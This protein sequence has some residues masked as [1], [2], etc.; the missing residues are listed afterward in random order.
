[1]GETFTPPVVLR[2]NLPGGYFYSISYP[3][4]SCFVDGQGNAFAAWRE[5]RQYPYSKLFFLTY[6]GST[7]KTD[8]SDAYKTFHH[9][10][11]VASNGTAHAIWSV[12]QGG[13]TNDLYFSTTRG[14]PLFTSHRVFRSMNSAYRLNLFVNSRKMAN[15]VFSDGADLKLLRNLEY[16]TDTVTTLVAGGYPYTATKRSVVVDPTDR[17]WVSYL[18]RRGDTSYVNDPWLL[19]YRDILVSVNAHADNPT[20]FVLHQNYPNP[21]N[22]TTEIRYQTSEVSHLTLKVFDLLGREVA[23]LVDEV[24]GSGFKSVE[25]NASELASGVYFFRLT[26]GNFVATKKLMMVR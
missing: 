25:F 24:Q 11:A 1:M 17:V 6:N 23:T 13:G 26:A 20:S 8:S 7:A 18:R 15:A 14:G 21:F 2:E 4:V 22:P 12:D 16:G 5:Q 10:F 3:D 19:Q 9:A